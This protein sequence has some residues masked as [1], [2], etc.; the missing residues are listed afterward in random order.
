MNKKNIKN[1]TPLSVSE[2]ENYKKNDAI[3]TIDL[4]HQ[5][6]FVAQYIP[7]TL[8]SGIEG[9]F[10]KW[11]QLLIVDKSTQLLLILPTAKEQNCLNRLN[12]LGYT[13]IIGYLQGGIESWVNAK[14]TLTSINSI[15]A[16]SFVQKR[17]SEKLSIIDL[18]KASE[19]ENAH[20]TDATLIPL[21]IT[22]EFIENLNSGKEHHLF[23]GGGYRSVIAIS[24]L[25]KYGNRN[26]TNI[27]GGFKSIQNKLSA[28]DAN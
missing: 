17:K 7:N 11:I 16:T 4:R 20:I 15:S 27:E 18:R 6:Q 24:F 10:D 26:L 12:S 1:S 3:L 28:T 9:P 21:S 23:C 8:F 19:F 22:K 5:D 2:F 25:I 14:K 13:N